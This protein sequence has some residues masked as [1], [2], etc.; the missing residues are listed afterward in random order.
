M[1]SEFEGTEEMAETCGKTIS[2]AQVR[3][4]GDLAPGDGSMYKEK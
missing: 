3:N 1:K 2:E 4:K